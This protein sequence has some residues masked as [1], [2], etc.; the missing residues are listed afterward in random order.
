MFAWFCGVFWCCFCNS[1]SQEYI[2]LLGSVVFSGVVFVIPGAKNIFVCLVLWCILVLFLQFLEPR[3]CLFAWFCGVFWC[4]LCN[5][6]SQEYVCLLGS[7][8]FSGVVFVIPGAK[9]YVCL[10]GSVVFSG[11]SAVPEAK[12]YVCL[13]GSVVFSGGVFAI[14]E[15]KEYVCLHGSVVFS[16]GVFL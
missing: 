16:G 15:A 14:S 3:I 9:K 11:V 12:E 4:C 10:H 5:S 1:W 8:V 7:V 13:H 2:C 6:W